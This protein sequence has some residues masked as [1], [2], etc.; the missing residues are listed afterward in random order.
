LGGARLAKTFRI[1]GTLAV[2]AVMVSNISA[3]EVAHST[4]QLPPA[5]AAI[6]S[7]SSNDRTVCITSSDGKLSCS[8]RIPSYDYV[9]RSLSAIPYVTGAKKVELYLSQTGKGSLRGFDR[10]GS[11][12]IPK[13]RKSKPS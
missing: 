9:D 11:K 13:D 2:L 5:P 12:K 10:G 3:S 8:G 1:A 7:I 6:T 4:E